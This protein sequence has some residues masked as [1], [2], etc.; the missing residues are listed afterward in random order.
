MMTVIYSSFA[1]K[2]DY[3]T[4]DGSVYRH[5]QHYKDA[6]WQVWVKDEEVSY[7]GRWEECEEREEPEYKR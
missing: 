1:P 2:W 6:I 3:V 4:I 7:L 5:R